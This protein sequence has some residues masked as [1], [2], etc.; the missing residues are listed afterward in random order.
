MLQNADPHHARDFMVN[1]AT[2]FAKTNLKST[3]MRK[4]LQMKLIYDPGGLR[5]VVQPAAVMTAGEL[6]ENIAKVADSHGADGLQ[7]IKGL[8]KYADKAV[9]GS[10]NISNSYWEFFGPMIHG[11]RAEIEFLA[12]NTDAKPGTHV[13][14][15][16]VKPDPKIT[17]DV[18]AFLGNAAVSIKRQGKTLDNWVNGFGSLRAE[19]S[20]EWL[21]K[22]MT[23]IKNGNGGGNLPPSQSLVFRTGKELPSAATQERLRKLAARVKGGFSISF[24]KFDI[25]PPPNIN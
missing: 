24:E 13:T 4:I 15:E 9:D 10:G 2:V 17:S 1:M 22:Y 11:R 25:L 23:K 5:S 19:K 16:V 7:V 6:M 3:D 12:K 8:A 18:D 14:F 21:I 20:D